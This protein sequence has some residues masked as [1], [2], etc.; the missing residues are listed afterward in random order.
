MALRNWGNQRKPVNH[1]LVIMR[2]CVLGVLNT[3]VK[4]KNKQTNASIL[5]TE[6]KH[7]LV[8]R[9]LIDI[10]GLVTVNL[11]RDVDA[12]QLGPILAKQ[13][14]DL[15]SNALTTEPTRHPG[16]FLNIAVAFLM[17]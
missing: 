2:V 12:G 11:V 6:H 13:T 16:L 9:N 3:S 15:Q 10:F 1:L 8:G 17:L 14:L 4:H 5:V 7:N